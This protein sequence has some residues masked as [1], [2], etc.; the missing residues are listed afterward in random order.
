MLLPS[1]L[2][3]ARI[4]VAACQSLVAAQ[5]QTS[6]RLVI[7]MH[8]RRATKP[9]TEYPASSTISTRGNQPIQIGRR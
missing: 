7:F 9:A 2:Y 6:S 4:R 3:G 1:Y 5:T 8:F